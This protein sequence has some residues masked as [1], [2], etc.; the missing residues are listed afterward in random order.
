MNNKEKFLELRLKE[1]I[2]YFKDN[3]EEIAPSTKIVGPPHPGF[4]EGQYLIG[5]SPKQQMENLFKL[6]RIGLEES[7]W[8]ERIKYLES[9][10]ERIVATARES[11]RG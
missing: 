9:K 1:A 8:L 4:P 6:A 7:R 10:L 3:I 11:K 2:D 5:L